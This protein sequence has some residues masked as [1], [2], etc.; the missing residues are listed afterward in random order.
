MKHILTYS[1]CSR[2]RIMFT[3]SSV[4][5]DS[6]AMIPS[7]ITALLLASPICAAKQPSAARLEG[8]RLEAGP[9]QD[10]MV[11]NVKYLLANSDVDNMLWLFRHLAG[12][13]NPPGRKD[14]WENSY[15]SHAGQFLMG[16]GNT[17]YWQEQPELR[18]RLDRLIDGMKACQAADGS[19]LVPG[20]GRKLDKQWGYSMQMF[21]HGMVAA[22]RS[23]NADA[24]PLLAAAYRHYASLLRSE[25]P[26]FALTS[27]L[28]YQG[29]SPVCWTTSRHWARPTTC[30]WPSEASSTSHGWM[31]WLSCLQNPLENMIL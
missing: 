1:F 8:T 12:D 30:C 5:D 7:L 14:G 29:I 10:A 17:L 23:G 28:N 22:A 11:A 6:V 9:L 19:L 20:V 18:R 13:P 25:P 2:N 4:R 31:R 24:Y 16:A 3:G 21:T 26:R 27:T 15:P